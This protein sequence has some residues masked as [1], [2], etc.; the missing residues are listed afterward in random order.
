[1]MA[2]PC[3][4]E[5]RPITYLRVSVTDRCN[6]RCVYCMPEEGV[7][8]R[9]HDEILRYEEITR[10]VRVAAKV[11]LKQVRLT[12]GEPLV[13]RRIVD[14]VRQIAATPGIED[15]SM[16]TNG[17]LLGAFA[18]DLHAAGLRRVNISLDTL[19]PERFLKITRRGN[20]EDVLRGIAA[21]RTAG[22]E[23]VKINVVAVRGM[24]DDEAVAFAQR[25]RDE[26]WN[27]RFIEVMPLGAGEHWSAESYIPS[28]ETK[29]QIE[30]ALGPLEPAALEGNGPARYWRLPGAEGTIGFISPISEH[31]C[32]LC[33]RLRLT[34]DGKLMPCLLSDRELDL[35]ALLRGGADDAAIR[36]L[37]L[38]AV[39]MKPDRH[40]LDERIVPETHL[41]SQVGG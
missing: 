17:T 36:N 21:A 34:A 35:R 15:V 9:A 27:V 4:S 19:D 30:E 5:R 32:S 39:A 18:D 6:L 28:A 16:T 2:A 37:L 25:T 3:D 31:F 7:A 12:G 1:M 33:N 38:R 22:L 41:M 13:R 11:G 8:A 29:A 40:H 20:L 23:P 26:G 24:N 14:L 10:V